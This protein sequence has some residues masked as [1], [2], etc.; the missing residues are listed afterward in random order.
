MAVGRVH[1]AT[2]P[3]LW[4][5]YPREKI[6]P[7]VGLTF[8]SAFWQQGFV[9]V[10]GRIMVLLVTLEKGD[11]E[12]QFQYEDRFLAPDLFQWQSQNRTAQDRAH[13]QAIRQHAQ[14]GIAV[15]LFIRRETKLPGGRAAPF[16]YCGEVDFVE[17]EGN[18][19]ITV[20]WRLREPVPQRLRDLLKVPTV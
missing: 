20:Q 10:G 5:S 11:K 18:K 16:I 13:G 7:L 3:E 14:R 15:H 4:R 19:P 12:K 1:S 2:T 17:W 9:F 8:S 6:P